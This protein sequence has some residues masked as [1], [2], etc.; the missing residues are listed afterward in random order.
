VTDNLSN[1]GAT[2]GFALDVAN[3][4]IWALSTADGKS[5]ATDNYTAVNGAATAVSSGN[6]DNITLST[7]SVHNFVVG[8]N[9]TFSATI[10]DGSSTALVTNDNTYA[11]AAVGSQSVTVTLSLT[12]VSTIAVTS[13]SNALT[14][15][16]TLVSPYLY[17][18]AITSGTTVTKNE[19]PIFDANIKA[20]VQYVDIAAH[21]SGDRAAVCYRDNTG[22]AATAGTT[23]VRIITASSDGTAVAAMGSDN[24][25]TTAGWG[26]GCS[27]S[28]YGSSTSA[29]DNGTLWIAKGIDVAS[30]ATEKPAV[31]VL[32]STDNGTSFSAVGTSALATA[33]STNEHGTEL[34]VD[35][36]T[37]SSGNPVIAVMANGKIEVYQYT[38]SAIER[39]SRTFVSTGLAETPVSVAV[40][41]SVY[42][43]SYFN[44]S[45][46]PKTDIFYDE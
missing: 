36:A 9:V 40:N 30:S 39:I 32:K 19:L 43:V 29:S 41:G 21:P 38:G 42:A 44:G 28:W 13:G 26:Y 4:T 3:S 17:A 22:A 7:P 6:V 35:L 31:R 25:S 33:L 20:A 2:L 15:P 8:D 16:P 23:Y 45:G 18:T 12:S 27:M 5:F 10:N 14:S 1:G 24:L 46:A 11:V 34:A 37:N